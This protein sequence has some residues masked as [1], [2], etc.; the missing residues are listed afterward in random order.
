MSSSIKVK[1]KSKIYDAWQWVGQT[2]WEKEPKWVQDVI[3]HWSPKHLPIKTPRGLVY[4]NN[5]D[6]LVNINDSIYFFDEITF[7][8]IYDI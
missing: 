1:S 5:G 8:S 2:D 3:C 7:N 6:Y 4:L